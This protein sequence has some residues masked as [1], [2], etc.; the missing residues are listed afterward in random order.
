MSFRLAAE[1]LIM[2]GVASSLD[3]ALTKVTAS[4][5]DGSALETLRRFVA[6]NGGDAKALDDFSRLPQPGQVVDVRADRDGYVAAIDGRALGLLAMDLGAGRRNRN[7]VLDLGVGIRVLTQVGQK[8]T[9]GERIVKVLATASQL[10][11]P[12]LYLSTI[13]LTMTPNAPKPWLV[14]SIGC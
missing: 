1:M 7:D 11:L 14:D 3:E 13:E 8:V 10:I 4:I 9:K 2:G 12:D 6:L 5:L